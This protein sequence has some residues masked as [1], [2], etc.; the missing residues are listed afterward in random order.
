MAVEWSEQAYWLMDAPASFS[1]QQYMQCTY[2]IYEGRVYATI[3]VVE[4]R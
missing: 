4:K 2:S 3:V 1:I